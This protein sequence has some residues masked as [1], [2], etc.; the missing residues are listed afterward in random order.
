[1]KD[2]QAYFYVSSPN[3]SLLKHIKEG[4]LKKSIFSLAGIKFK[5]ASI[6]SYAGP[7]FTRGIYRFS[8]LSPIVLRVPEN[9]DSGLKKIRFMYATDD[10]FQTAL[11]I[12]LIKRFVSYYSQIPTTSTFEIKKIHRFKPVTYRIGT[13]YYRGNRIVFEVF[14]SP[15]LLKFAF[16]CGLGEYTH[17]G[18]GMVK[19]LAEQKKLKE[20][21]NKKEKPLQLL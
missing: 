17:L 14:G 1:M 6:D 12:N 13:K 18:F 5:I 9:N 8:T 21:D 15:E 3:D 19:V 20:R 7:K 4:L 2:E 10:D 16:E 11:K